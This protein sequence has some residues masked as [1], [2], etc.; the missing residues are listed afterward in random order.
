MAPNGIEPRCRDSASPGNPQDHTRR[1]GRL[2]DLPGPGPGALQVAAQIYKERSKKGRENAGESQPAQKL[3]KSRII[4]VGLRI[5][6]IAAGD[7]DKL[8]RLVG[9]RKELLAHGVGDEPVVR[10]VAL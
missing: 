3:E 2:P 5:V 10:T 4:G 7:H 1:A 9:R 6:M 8:L